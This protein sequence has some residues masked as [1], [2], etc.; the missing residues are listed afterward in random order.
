MADGVMEDMM[1]D[2]LGRCVWEYIDNIMIC[3]DSE[4]EYLEHIR[5]VCECLRK[6]RYYTS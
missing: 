3:S 2:L 5:N 6:G 1:S 4:E